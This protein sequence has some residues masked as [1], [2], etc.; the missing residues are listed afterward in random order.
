LIDIPQ[1][2]QGSSASESITL[3]NFFY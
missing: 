2:I 3:T 1:A